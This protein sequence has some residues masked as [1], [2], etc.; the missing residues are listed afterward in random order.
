MSTC[1][2]PLSITIAP[3]PMVVFPHVG[4]G[5]AL[6]GLQ[7]GATHSAL[8][9]TWDLLLF[10]VYSHNATGFATMSNPVGDFFTPMALA[11]DAQ[12]AQDGIF[13]VASAF[14]L[15]SGTVTN[16]Q[17]DFSIA[18]N[19]VCFTVPI[20]GGSTVT[21]VND[22]AGDTTPG[23]I[24]PPAGPLQV[25]LFGLN[26]FM[27]VGNIPGGS[28]HYE[29]SPD[30]QSGATSFSPTFLNTGPP[31]NYQFFFPPKPWLALGVAVS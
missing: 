10:L 15:A 3:A 23:I 4:T 18:T 27:D 26:G 22:N 11:G 28:T 9:G 21:S 14:W 6:A 2:K 19:Y 25:S 29:N 13:Q 5:H 12:S 16:C 7:A 31:F 24:S 30:Q 1:A 17:C 20:S 8:A